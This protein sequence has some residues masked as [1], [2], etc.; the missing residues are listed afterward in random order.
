MGVQ[1]ATQS[2]AEDSATGDGAQ[3]GGDAVG[4]RTDQEAVVGRMSGGPHRD[5]QL[6]YW[7][8]A[9]RDK[10]CRSR[11]EDQA[12][13]RAQASCCLLLLSSESAPDESS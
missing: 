2:S 6:T 9:V 1:G 12:G 7:G 13:N 8:A 10:V 5:Q 11:V 4:T 3:E